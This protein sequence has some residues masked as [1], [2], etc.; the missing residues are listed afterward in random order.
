MC[1]MSV[2]IANSLLDVRQWCLFVVEAFD[3][4]TYSQLPIILGLVE[5]WLTEILSLA[6]LA[7]TLLQASFRHLQLLKETPGAFTFRG[8]LTTTLSDVIKRAWSQNAEAFVSFS[9]WTAFGPLLHELLS[10]DPGKRGDNETNRMLIVERRSLR[11]LSSPIPSEKLPRDFLSANHRELLIHLLN[12]F[13]DASDLGDLYTTIVQT[14]QETDAR[15]SI[16]MLLNWATS[17][18]STGATGASDDWRPLLA[19]RILLKLHSVQQK[20]CRRGKRKGENPKSPG[21]LVSDVAQLCNTWLEKLDEQHTGN[22]DVDFER[23]VIL[24]GELARLSLFSYPRFLHRLTAR[25]LAF[26]PTKSHVF[27]QA[28]TGISDGIDLDRNYQVRL[29]RAVPIA[30]LSASLAH[31][32]R[33][34]IYGER[35]TES[36]EEAVHR[37]A[38]RELSNALNFLNDYSGDDRSS[39]SRQDLMDQLPHVWRASFHV[40]FRLMTENVLP[41][42]SRWIKSAE[43]ISSGRVAVLLT[44]LEEARDWHT[45]A[46]FIELTIRRCAS[47]VAGV[48]DATAATEVLSSLVTVAAYVALRPQLWAVVETFKPFDSGLQLLFDSVAHL[49]PSCQKVASLSI[50][51]ASNG[52]IKSKALLA[53]ISAV[54]RDARQASSV[55]TLNLL[56]SSVEDAGEA[57]QDPV[58]LL[59]MMTNDDTEPTPAVSTRTVKGLFS[60]PVRP[61][62]VASE[63]ADSPSEVEKLSTSLATLVRKV[64]I[65][66]EVDIDALFRDAAQEWLQH[67]DIPMGAIKPFVLSVCTFCVHGHIGTQTIL[68]HLIEPALSRNLQFD[69]DGR[70]D[71]NGSIVVL[72]EMLLSCLLVKDRLLNIPNTCQTEVLRRFRWAAASTPQLLA[73]AVKLAALSTHPGSSAIG[74]V[75][76]ASRAELIKAIIALPQVTDSIIASPSKLGDLVRQEL[77]ALWHQREQAIGVIFDAAGE[78][79]GTPCLLTASE[80]L[81][82]DLAKYVTDLNPLQVPFA[83]EQLGFLLERMDAVEAGEQARAQNQLQKCGEAIFARFFLR[84]DGSIREGLRMWEIG[85]R[86]LRTVLAGTGFRTLESAMLNDETDKTARQ[87]LTAFACLLQ[88][89]SDKGRLP[90]VSHD[91]IGPLFQSAVLRSSALRA[92]LPNEVATSLDIKSDLHFKRN[93]EIIWLLTRSPAAWTTSM[94]RGALPQIMTHLLQRLAALTATAA[95]DTGVQADF[96][97]LYDLATYL[98]AEMPPD[99]LSVCSNALQTAF[100][101]DNIANFMPHP[102]CAARHAQAFR[103]L[104]PHGR[105][106]V[107]TTSDLVQATSLSEAMRQGDYTAATDRP[108]SWTESFDILAPLQPSSNA[109]AGAASAP[110]PSVGSAAT[111]TGERKNDRLAQSTRAKSCNPLTLDPLSNQSSL[112]LS[113][114]GAIRTT[115]LPADPTADYRA[116]DTLRTSWP[117]ISAGDLDTDGWRV[118]RSERE[119]F[120]PTVAPG[121]GTDTAVPR[122]G[123]A[124]TSTRPGSPSSIEGLV[125]LPTGPV[126]TMESFLKAQRQKKHEAALAAAAR[127]AQESHSEGGATGA[128]SGKVIHEGPDR[129]TTAK[130]RARLSQGK[131]TDPGAGGSEEA[132]A[133]AGNAV[134]NR[135][136]KNSRSTAE[137]GGTDGTGEA[138]VPNSGRKRRG[139]SA[140]NTSAGRSN[141]SNRGSRKKR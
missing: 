133:S 16:E 101:I 113:S 1:L 61:P 44:L 15:H 96:D 83:V 103:R 76:R 111:S 80:A 117:A 126:R 53:L 26:N 65:L 8:V 32:R 33:A 136:R 97:Y 43:K 78:A 86:S 131:L 24:Y 77:R 55:P 95:G 93:V 7:P 9:L 138:S 141:G 39:P 88:H 118:L 87:A 91:I 132:D 47:L 27:A 123:V 37:R 12:T 105:V 82:S 124:P 10:P 75:A 134:N 30:N 109:Q 128:A 73:I 129:S 122:T 4:A 14:I 89:G 84:N 19:S 137:D 64:A 5:D 29:L 110:S 63:A 6:H 125:G 21:W 11:F 48:A 99:L 23:L 46:S 102:S 74:S 127:V 104:L 35:T 107:L 41:A 54:R 70:N 56:S 69:E 85:G 45:S 28:Q 18:G 112:S 57:E 31:Q 13:H 66:E 98:E 3:T 100:A 116:E 25:G 130:K 17:T 139:S 36:R 38:L 92:S 22:Q 79:L 52:R 72:C 90:P 62:P 121:S 140:S 60:C 20:Q 71:A 50:P 34:A 94:V 67:T 120:F 42:A 106:G 135:K 58:R 68:D 115:A 108:W 51:S 2:L 40:R 114:F 49:G 59:Q 119:P 81:G